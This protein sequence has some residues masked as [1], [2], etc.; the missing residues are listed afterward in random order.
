[1]Y[2]TPLFARYQMSGTVAYR[3]H[4]YVQRYTRADLELLAALNEARDTL[5][6][7]ATRRIL[8]RECL[9]CW[10]PEYELRATVCDPLVQS[11]ASLQLS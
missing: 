2:V 6:G 10:N 4:R 3:R 9:Q 11:A 5:S 8:E 7:S 1:M